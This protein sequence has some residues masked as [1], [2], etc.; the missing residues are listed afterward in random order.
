M[1]TFKKPCIGICDVLHN[2]AYI[3]NNAFVQGLQKHDCEII[4]LTHKH[5]FL[6]LD[7]LIQKCQAVFFAYPLN[8][9]KGKIKGEPWEF[10]HK[11]H[12]KEQCEEFNIKQIILDVGYIKNLH[13]TGFNEYE[14]CYS[15][16]GYNNFKNLAEYHNKNSS[17]DRW[18]QLKTKIKEWKTGNEILLFGQTV[19]G[20][21]TQDVYIFK[22]YKKIVKRIVKNTNKQIRIRLHPRIFKRKKRRFSVIE[23]IGECLEKYKGRYIVSDNEKIE[24]DLK[25][26]NAS[27]TF[28][29]NACIRSLLNGVPTICSS[30]K[31]MTYDISDNDI[32][33]IDNLPTF[34]RNQFFYDLAYTQWNLKEIKKGICWEHLKQGLV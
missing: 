1:G 7:L 26:A 9:K 2:H 21:S 11:L 5:T 27:I 16:I 13:D 14:D 23:T 25:N 8:I 33:N 6:E 18:K 31:A 19:Y 17:K 3:L 30:P 12:V 34:E 22:W 28:S 15:A 32:K 10:K 20:T 4:I 24:D 29:S